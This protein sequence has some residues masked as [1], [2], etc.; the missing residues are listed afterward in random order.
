MMPWD[1]FYDS[2]VHIHFR[3]SA[4]SSNTEPLALHFALQAQKKFHSPIVDDQ[5]LLRFEALDTWK[6][7]CQGYNWK[8]TVIVWESCFELYI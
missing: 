7:T 3:P 2:Q 8:L 5:E 4:L 1:A 6:Y